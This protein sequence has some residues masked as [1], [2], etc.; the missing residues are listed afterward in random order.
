MAK[1]FFSALTVL[2]IVAAA[3]GAPFVTGWLVAHGAMGRENAIV[4]RRFSGPAPVAALRFHADWCGRCQVLAP[5]WAEA[6]SAIEDGAIRAE[7]VDMTFGLK[8][9]DAMYRRRMAAISAAAVGVYEG[10]SHTTGFV[11]LFEPE[12]G[13]ELG[14]IYPNMSVRQIVHMLERATGD[15]A[16][17]TRDGPGRGASSG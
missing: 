10:N 16:A 17:A 13:R 6:L 14:R 15:A 4:E 11:I 7:V 8:S 12:S 5:K 1:A 3:L 9:S 2:A